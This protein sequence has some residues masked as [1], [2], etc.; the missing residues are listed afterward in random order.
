MT[1]G[2]PSVAALLCLGLWLLPACSKAPDDG[3]QLAAAMGCAPLSGLDAVLDA[4]AAQVLLIGGTNEAGLPAFAQAICS[5]AARGESVQATVAAGS[6][7]VW[8]V[9]QVAQWSAAGAQ[10]ELTAIAEALDEDRETKQA[11]LATRLLAMRS[12]GDRVIALLD[13]DS[14]A[15]QPLGLS[16]ET[17]S[18][19]GARLPRDGAVSLLALESGRAQPRAALRPFED[20]PDHGAARSYDGMIEVVSPPKDLPEAPPID[21]LRGR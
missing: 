1:Y 19:V 9:T 7:P 8:L 14:A 6:A 3:S 5:A 12:S 11:A 18:P 17:W 13:A 15:R 2:R 10:I 16:G 21:A 20:I 4:P